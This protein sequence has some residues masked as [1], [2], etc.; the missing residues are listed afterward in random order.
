MWLL[1]TSGLLQYPTTAVTACSTSGI[2]RVNSTCSSVLSHNLGWLQ[3]SILLSNLACSN[4]LVHHLEKV[5]E[6]KTYLDSVHVHIGNNPL[7][8]FQL[9]AVDG[10][11]KIL[12]HDTILINN[13]YTSSLEV[14]RKS[15]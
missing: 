8:A 14:S 12:S 15:S 10:Q 9:A 2:P 6:Y 3:A 5:G 1:F 11:R 4:L 13:F 7:L